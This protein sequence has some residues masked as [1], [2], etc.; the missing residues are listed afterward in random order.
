MANIKY[1]QTSILIP[2]S[3]TR[4]QRDF[5]SKEIIKRIVTR[6]KM[7]IDANGAGF[8][9]YDKEYA[10]E[11][12]SSHVNLTLTGDMLSELE[13]LN[14]NT[15]GSITVGYPEG[16]ELEG[17]VEGNQSGIR[18]KSNKVVHPRNFIGISQKEKDIILAKADQSAPAEKTEYTKAKESFISNFLSDFMPNLTKDQGDLDE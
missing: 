16:H 6:T 10:K 13:V 4:D 15:P 2:K 12:G 17:Q 11:K 8:A 7:G 3:Y 5:I 14:I 1:T 9:A 18:G